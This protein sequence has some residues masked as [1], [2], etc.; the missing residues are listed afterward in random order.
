MWA[1]A[2]LS[3][4]KKGQDTCLGLL[5]GGH[6]RTESQDSAYTAA[7]P[8]DKVFDLLSP[9]QTLVPTPTIGSRGVQSCTPWGSV[10][11]WGPPRWTR[12]PDQGN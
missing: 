11:A 6:Q 12:L 4:D 7:Q 1:P 9:E 10:W 5:D 2:Y 3:A 8:L